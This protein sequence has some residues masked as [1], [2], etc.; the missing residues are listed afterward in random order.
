MTVIELIEKLKEVP[1][2]LEVWIDIDSSLYVLDESS[3]VAPTLFDGN[4]V[5]FLTP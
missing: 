4:E 1:Q 3:E 5:V 2:D